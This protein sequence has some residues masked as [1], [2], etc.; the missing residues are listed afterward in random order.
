MEKEILRL[1]RA[2]STRG[3]IEQIAARPGA[4]HLPALSEEALSAREYRAAAN[5]A[6]AG[7]AAGHPPSGDLACRLLP[8]IED[9]Y[10]ATRFLGSVEH[11]LLDALLESAGSGRNLPSQQGLVLFL[12]A[13]SA[14]DDAPPD[15]LLRHI[16]YAARDE[17]EPECAMLIGLAALEVGDPDVLTVARSYVRLADNPGGLEIREQI[18]ERFSSPVLDGLPDTP[19]PE[20]FAGFTVRKTRPDVGRNAPCP[21]GSGRKYKK[22]CLSKEDHRDESPD[23]SVP[24]GDRA[25]LHASMSDAQ[26]EGLHPLELARI[27]PDELSTGR[28]IHAAEDLARYRSF[29]EAERCLET[30]SSRR[31][32]P[33]GTTVDSVRSNMLVSALSARDREAIERILGSVEEPGEIKA[34]ADLGLAI[35]AHD[36]DALE[37][38]EDYAV[39]G[40]REPDGDALG[41]LC[42]AL[43]FFS[44]ALGI[45]VARGALDPDHPEVADGLLTAIEQ[46]RDQLLLPPD[47]P[48]CEIYAALATSRAEER[49]DSDAVQRSEELAAE[50]QELRD[51]AAAA[52]GREITARREKARLEKSLEEALRA[53][54]ENRVAAEEALRTEGPSPETIPR[55]RE[56]I[57]RFHDRIDEL[58]EER[59][60]YRRQISSF[61][62]RVNKATALE[63][64]PEVD[65]E[66][67]GLE[68]ADDGSPDRRHV[69]LPVFA[70]EFRDAIRGVPEHVARDAVTTAGTLASGSAAGWTSV[71]KLKAMDDVRSA[72]I[73][74]HRILFRLSGEDEIEFL[75]LIHR[76]ELDGTLRRLS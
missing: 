35:L 5:L 39:E 40:L 62:S 59:R 61:Q 45:L 50:A 24:W 41:K 42:A 67:D 14:D 53:A 65:D 6:L 17:H 25:R 43:L 31:D 8:A 23:A 1:A 10:V 76:R 55:L 44:P 30:L 37:R 15:E 9:M 75:R 2:A 26:F 51:T 57:G 4:E 58:M 52:R 33:E 54:E 73:G 64:E 13:V 46:S 49:M 27:E 19:P 20:R 18:L 60:Q 38:I 74:R 16:R 63:H 34:A 21:C 12:A 7:A 71:K 47:D 56:K 66:A 22:C 36:P 11:G 32:L 68:I 3:L 48:A 29:P 72:R 70:R 69:R 28:L